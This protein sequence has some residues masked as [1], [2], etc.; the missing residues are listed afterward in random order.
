MYLY[1]LVNDKRDELSL[2]RHVH[3][4]I[5][6]RTS[7][8][9]F[10]MS[11]RYFA[12]LIF[13]QSSFVGSTDIRPLYNIASLQTE[14]QINFCV[15]NFFIWQIICTKFAINNCSRQCYNLRTNYKYFVNTAIAY[16]CYTNLSITITI[17]C[18]VNRYNYYNKWFSRK[19][20]SSLLT[21]LQSQKYIAT[22]RFCTWDMGNLRYLYLYF[23]IICNYFQFAR[24]T[25]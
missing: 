11:I 13:S 9:I 25:K 21:D 7:H 17:M 6:M 8:L 2:F 5:H 19:F 16:S 18:Y 15:E 22:Y 20:Y 1:I 3:L 24:V 14:R 12:E 23:F 4:S 10:E